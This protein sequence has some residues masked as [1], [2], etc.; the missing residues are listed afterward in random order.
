MIAG[1]LGSLGS[2]NRCHAAVSTLDAQ[3]VIDTGS[4]H[5]LPTR[6]AQDERPFGPRGEM[7]RLGCVRLRARMQLCEYMSSGGEPG[8]G[9]S[10]VTA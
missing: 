6:I 2:Y 8:G 5:A 3:A 4:W 7:A 9:A 1:R 10:L